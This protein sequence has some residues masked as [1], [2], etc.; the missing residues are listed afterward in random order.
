MARKM[1]ER[2]E[3]LRNFI[4]R[5]LKQVR[6]GDIQEAELTLVDLWNDVGCAYVCVNRQPRLAVGCPVPAYN[7]KRDGDYG[8]WLVSHNL[9]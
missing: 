8:N 3:G 6:A 7:A 4:E 1:N 9:D 5:A 2:T